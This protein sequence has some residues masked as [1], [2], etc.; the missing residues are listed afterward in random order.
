[1]SKLIPLALLTLGAAASVSAQTPPDEAMP[2]RPAK[3]A[4][5]VMPQVTINGG[6]PSDMEERRQSTAGKQI[7][8]R[9]ELDRNGDTNLGDVLKRLPGV[10]IGGRAGRG[11]EV[12]MRGLGSGYTQVL[13]NGERPPAGFSMESLSPD[14]VERVE[15]MRGPVAEHSTRAIAGTINIVLRDGYQQH[16]VQL[17]VGDQVEQG[18]HAPNISVTAPGKVGALTYT[19]SGSLQL[20]RQHDRTSTHNTD[21][22]DDGMVSKEQQLASESAATNKAV[23]VTPRLSYKFDSGDTVNFQPFLMHQVSD[24]AADGTLAQPITPPDQSQEYFSSAQQAHSSSTFLRGFGNWLHRMPG[25][26][27]LDVKFG[28]GLGK[29][30]S[31]SLRNQF[32]ADGS[33]KQ[34]F[35]DTDS[36]RDHS[37]NNGGKYTSPLGQGHL[38]AAGWDLE[39]SH[40]EES[41]VS[42]DK[43]GKPQFADSG[44]NLSADTRRVA[45][46][47]QDE[48]D[49]TPQ[50]AMYVGARWEG[51]RTTSERSSGAVS[52]TSKVF[53]PLL[54]GVWK[55]PGHDKD[56]LR[57]SLTKSYKSPNVQDLIALPFQSRL[58][59]ATSPDRT[60]NPDLKPELA[61]GLD[62]AY[63]HYLGRNGIV[64][65]SGFV[66]DID[67]LIR[68]DLQ[69]RQTDLG[70]RWVSTPSNIGHARTSGI[71][72]EAKFS[73]S[74]VMANAPHIDLRS[75]YSRFWSSVDGIAGPDNRLDQQA[76]QT[77]NVGMDYRMQS[78]PLTLGG[79]YN[80][81]PAIRVQTSVSQLVETS[82][83]RVLDVYGLWRFDARTQLRLSAS[84]V[85]AEDASG[86]NLVYANG[87]ASQAATLNPT[88][89]QWS[90]RLETKF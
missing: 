6:R 1:M 47:A 55:I 9:E 59:S 20:N 63:E 68:R 64:S 41:K 80:W 54:H 87:L 65:V 13:L 7:Y 40:R 15:V 60:G 31:H 81:T 76:K 18:R 27:K 16:A 62:L 34:R 79:S 45:V 69:Q 38:L 26:A 82:P 88:F 86:H 89:T 24:S 28:F 2:A 42:L 73:L 4:D 49:I 53:S 17:K 56:Q 23:H 78:V 32:D 75:N 11:G 29:R 74:D 44:D 12:R 22:G 71:E 67:N 72:V 14:Q 61:T 36:T 51:I 85:L 3:A 10:T 33:L 5:K 90:V 66:R 48:W 58:N 77:A 35:T 19:L 84:N 50:W 21:T 25:A 46:F 52:N 30:D 8:G 83:K 43:D 70:L 39:T 37:L 57:A